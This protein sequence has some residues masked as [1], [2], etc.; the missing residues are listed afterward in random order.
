MRL[1]PDC[2]RDILFEI[3]EFAEYGQFYVYNPSSL[4]DGSFLKD[5][6]SATVMYHVRQC[7][8]SGYLHNVNWTHFEYVAIEDLTPS[9]H[10][11]LA[12]IRSDSVWGHVKEISKNIG[13]N[14]LSILAQIATGVLTSFIQKELKLI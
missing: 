9:G 12:D 6:D 14:S 11:F 4:P 7:S 10:H 1:N 2:I 5:Y 13:S 8:Q 3:E